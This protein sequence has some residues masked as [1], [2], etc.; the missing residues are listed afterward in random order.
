M[1]KDKL[2]KMFVEVKLYMFRTAGYLNILNFLMIALMFVSTTVYQWHFI[3]NTFPNKTLFMVLLFVLLIVFVF[4]FGWLDTVLKLWRTESERGYTPER[5]P[6][7][8]FIAFLCADKLNKLPAEQQET[9]SKE[10]EQILARCDMTEEFNKFKEVTKHVGG[11]NG[12]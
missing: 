3:S 10:F 12:T 2:R 7:M 5:N 11:K 9:M 4:T 6:L 1:L 8:Y